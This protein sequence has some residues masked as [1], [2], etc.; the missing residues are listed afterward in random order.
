MA[1]STLNP[2]DRLATLAAQRTARTDRLHEATAGLLAQL[3]K[4]VR[5]GDS[6]IVDG[7]E[8]QLVRRRSNIG[9]G[10][11]WAFGNGDDGCNALE[12]EVDSERF[13]HGDFHCALRGPSRALLVEFGQRADRFV[14]ALIAHEE[15]RAVEM[16][17]AIAGV[18][19]AAE[20]V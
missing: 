6:A 8:L 15:A 12:D 11:F 13:M 9:Y 3:E 16:N 2:I 19:T 10:D 1:N 5:P 7:W 20:T 17:A 4:H 14:A 18:A